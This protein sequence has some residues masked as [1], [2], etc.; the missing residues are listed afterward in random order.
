[1]G[2]SSI[3][4]YSKSSTIQRDPESTMPF[5][6][7]YNI[8]AE[9]TSSWQLALNH[10]REILEYPQTFVCVEKLHWCGSSPRLPPSGIQGT[11]GASCLLGLTSILSLRVD[12]YKVWWNVKKIKVPTDYVMENRRVNIASGARQWMCIAVPA[13]WSS[14]AF[15]SSSCCELSRMY[16]PDG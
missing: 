2:K 1:M 10:R 15:D 7:R 3:P 12:Q 6:C 16:L 13:T 11:T 4:T 5:S 8:H 14:P 9:M